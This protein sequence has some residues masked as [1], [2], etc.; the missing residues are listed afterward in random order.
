MAP[1]IDETTLADFV[2]A[3]NAIEDLGDPPYGPGTPEWDDHL[4][5]ARRVAA[6]TLDDPFE[7]HF[8]LTRRILAPH[9]SGVPRGTE[10][11]IGDAQ[12]PDAGPHLR[13]HLGRF[14]RLRAAGPSDGESPAAFAWR[15]HHEFECVHPFVDGNGRTGRLLLDAVRL[16]HGLDWHTVTPGDDQRDYYRTIRRYRERHFACGWEW[17]RPEV[18][19]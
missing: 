4:D 9:E 6:G 10:V 13:A 15:I 11:W 14:A 7:I 12:A 2:R 8:V 17:G 18:C 16:A 5:A 3:S 1:A 19:G